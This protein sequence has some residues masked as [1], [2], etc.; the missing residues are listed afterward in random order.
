MS[1]CQFFFFHPKWSNIEIT[2]AND[3]REIANWREYIYIYI[4]V[5]R[6][7][8]TR[9]HYWSSLNSDRR[10][11]LSRYLYLGVGRICSG[12]RSTNSTA[13]FRSPGNDPAMENATDLKSRSSPSPHIFLFFFFL[14]HLSLFNVFCPSVPACQATYFKRLRTCELTEPIKMESFSE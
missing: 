9:E 10:L 3:R 1:N 13:G 12:E 7:L 4:G 2:R 6:G 11:N 14:L 8:Q 5:N